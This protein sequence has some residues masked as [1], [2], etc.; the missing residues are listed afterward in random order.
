MK[1]IDHGLWQSDPGVPLRLTRE[2]KPFEIVMCGT[3]E[4]V[5]TWD[6]KLFDAHGNE[7]AC[8]DELLMGD[9][10]SQCGVW[11]FVIDEK[12]PMQEACENHDQKYSMAAYQENHT[13]AEADADLERDGKLLGFARR[14]KFY[15]QVARTYGA[16]FWD[17]LKT[18]G[19]GRQ[20]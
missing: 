18:R 17:N 1:K 12:D 15:A 7:Y 13:R 10:D 20:V 9:T 3:T 14:A 6:R 5:I 4:L 8:E 19:K 11:P 16:R 2:Q